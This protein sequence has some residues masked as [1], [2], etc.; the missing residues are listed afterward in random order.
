MGIISSLADAVASRLLIKAT[1]IAKQPLADKAYLITIQ[2]DKLK[3]LPYVPGQHV[4]L[5]V[6]MGE[7]AGL[8][9]K[10]R[11]YSSWHYDSAAGTLQMAICTHGQG[12]GS[13]WALAVQPGGEVYLSSLQGKFTLDTSAESYL[14]IGDASALAHLYEL[15]R[16]LAGNQTWSGIVYAD[17]Q[18]E[19]FADRDGQQPF[20]FYE[21]P[22]NPIARLQE[23]IEQA[24]LDKPA[25]TI[26]YIGGDGR[27]CIALTNY[28]R[29]VKGWPNAR[30][31]VKPF[32]LPGRTGLE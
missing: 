26:V 32:W 24:L 7:P 9:D 27:V 3:Y 21:L 17:Q 14:F 2:A 18:H 23:L 22:P 6:G 8:K 16:H 5:F 25:N 10:V 13:T 15:R 30:I 28:F 11:T 20:D 29:K 31:R 4:R 1:V 12:P 19:L